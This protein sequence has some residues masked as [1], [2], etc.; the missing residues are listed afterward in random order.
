MVHDRRSDDSRAAAR[1]PTFCGMAWLA[2]IL[3]LLLK[4]PSDFPTP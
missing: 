2:D 1:F 4:S 3:D